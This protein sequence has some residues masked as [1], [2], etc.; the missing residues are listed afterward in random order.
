MSYVTFTGTYVKTDV[1]IVLQLYYSMPLLKVP[2]RDIFK[3]D[4]P[5]ERVE[6]YV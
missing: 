6:I 5:E 1:T 4:V 3:L 2:S